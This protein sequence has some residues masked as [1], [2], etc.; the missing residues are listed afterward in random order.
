[1]SKRTTKLQLSEAEVHKLWIRKKVQVEMVQDRGYTKNPSETPWLNSF[2]LFNDL[3]QE[4]KKYTGQSMFL[5]SKYYKNSDSINVLY[6]ITKIKKERIKGLESTI[7]MI[8]D[9]ANSPSPSSRYIIISNAII[10][11]VFVEDLLY[12]IEIFHIDF[13]AFNVNRHVL[14]QKHLFL[15]PEDTTAFLDR[16]GVRPN[17]LGA[18]AKSSPVVRYY[19]Y[20]LTASIGGLVWIVRDPIIPSHIPEMYYVRQI[21]DIKAVDIP[22]EPEVLEAEEGADDEIGDDV[23]DIIIDT[24]ADILGEA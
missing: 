19:G 16:T 24:G 15:S 18:I 13:F 10:S 8:N 1:M 4:K 3:F 12:Q 23:D 21:R 11:P 7:K 2:E 9:D 5:S 22:D 17:E 20:Q 6:H 14:T